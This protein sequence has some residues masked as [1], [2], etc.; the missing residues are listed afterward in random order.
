MEDI[1]HNVITFKHDKYKVE[2]D[3]DGNAVATT[4][5]QGTLHHC[6]DGKIYLREEN[7]T[8]HEL[9]PVEN[10]KE[11]TSNTD[12]VDIEFNCLY[13]PKKL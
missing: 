9:V 8:I 4:Q 6:T 1:D 2:K 11:E 3:E 5:I 7:G 10:D 13:N 12:E